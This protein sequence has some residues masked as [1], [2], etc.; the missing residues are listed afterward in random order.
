MKKKIIFFSFATAVTIIIILITRNELLINLSQKEEENK[1]T[2]ILKEKD[3]ERYLSITYTTTDLSVETGRMMNFYTYNLENKMLE[4]KAQIPFNSQYALGA[5]SLA[6]NKIYYSYNDVEEQGGTDHLYEYDLL[7]RQSFKLETENYAYNDVIPIDDKLLV[8][9]VPIHAIGTA[10]FN[11]E[12][13]QF[14]YLYDK[15]DTGDGYRDFL[16]TTRPVPL[17]Y[18]YRHKTFINVC[19]SEKEFYDED[20]RSDR[21][22]IVNNIAL[23]DLDLKV[24]AEYKFERTLVEEIKAISLLSADRAIMATLSTDPSDMEHP[25]YTFYEI[26]F[27]DQTCIE[28]NSPMPK[29]NYIKNYITLDGG[30]SFYVLG[31]TIEGKS[32]LFYYESATNNIQPI[33]LD[34]YGVND[35]DNHVV[36][37]CVM[38]G[39]DK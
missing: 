8:T 29:L 38:E 3:N 14:T 22:P 20:I 30:N 21:K 2:Q 32:G 5:V 26:S 9:T 27:S 24:K 13:R 28:I 10:I 34:E 17:N 35:I 33:L 39:R 12:S 19:V 1:V 16:F 4:N 31:S 23:V 37:F 36:N 11:L 25:F 7:K 18:D 15:E 6:K